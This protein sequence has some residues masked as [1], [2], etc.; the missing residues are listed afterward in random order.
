MQMTP[1]PNQE[2][3]LLTLHELSTLARDN[4]T[5]RL[6]SI[7]LD[8]RVTDP[9]M[10][11]AWRP[12]LMT[13]VR[14]ARAR[15]SDIAELAEFDRA[16]AWLDNPWPP[17]D[18]V[19][20][21]PGWV[22]FLAPDGPRYAS[23]VPMR[24]PTLVAWRDGPV[25]SPYVRVLKQQSPVI[26]ALVDSRSARLFHYAWGTLTALPGMTLAAK[27]EVLERAG[28]ET[29]ATSSPAPRGALGTERADHRRRAI[30]QRMAATLAARVVELASDNG[31]VLIG[32][33]TEWAALAGE[34]LPATLEGRVTISDALDHDA[35][36]DTIA[37][38]AKHAAAAMR[39]VR[40][41]KLVDQL[42]ERLGSRGRSALGV[43]AMRR[44]LDAGAVDLLLLTSQYVQAHPR[45]AEN[46]VRAA[47]AL[48]ADVETVSGDAAAQLEQNGDGVGAR[49]RFS[50]DGM[51]PHV[52]ATSD[53]HV[54]SAHA[55]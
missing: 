27:D 38:A 54:D 52:A 31:W 28:A 48:G 23:D 16:A 24:V 15:I 46:D 26:V 43:P 14:D 41:R 44:A 39:E 21:A 35:T 34:A 12:A 18:A 25:I 37:Q 30:F 13:A 55:D 49:L 22:A 5:T 32:G 45:E 7:Y 17:L 10:R 4:A 51:A 11:H 19:F 29:H 1:P 36:D 47:L 8:A 3:A 6:L 2:A 33:T 20:G 40:A 42:F 50:L 53:H 9:A